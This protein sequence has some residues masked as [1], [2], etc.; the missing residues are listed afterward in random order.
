MRQLYPGAFLYMEMRLGKTLPTIRHCLKSED[1]LPVLVLAPKPIHES[2]KEELILE[3]VL[4]DRIHQFNSRKSNGK[5]KAFAADVDWV[6]AS[7]QS[8]K[9]YGLIKAREW[10]TIIY[11]ESYCLSK[12]KSGISGYVRDNFDSKTFHVSL[13]GNPAAETPI[14]YWNQFLC[15]IG[16]FGKF[17]TPWDLYEAF[18]IRD[19]W[20]KYKLKSPALEKSIVNRVR[21]FA[22]CLTRK[23]AG[24]GG[25]KEYLTRYCDIA[26]VLK[27][28]YDAIILDEKKTYF[29]WKQRCTFEYTPAIKALHLAMICSGIDPESGKLVGRNKIN[30]LL[31]LIRTEF[32][33]LQVVVFARYLEELRIIQGALPNSFLICGETP[34]EKQAE[35]RKDFMAG[36]YQ[37]AVLGEDTCKMGLN[38]S[39]APVAV[40]MS[41]SF[42]GDVR[43]QSEDRIISAMNTDG[44]VIVDMVSRN[45]VDE[46][47]SR[48]VQDKTKRS[49]E[50]LAADALTLARGIYGR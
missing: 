12:P 7:Y 48:L 2:W 15:T 27:S 21:R 32:M 43:A 36:K 50:D 49:K 39:C 33:G 13:S 45:G 8:A 4:I 42:A 29:N 22:F 16:S 14:D 24:V 6:I 30:A 20:G 23:E 9:G 5:G 41:N 1:Y 19:D 34:K 37:F 3:G 46:Y 25:K 11:D 18:T 47:I 10:G 35:Y 26:G 44:R 31:E 40:Y 38:F 28:K 17:T